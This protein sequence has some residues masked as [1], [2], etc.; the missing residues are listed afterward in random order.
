MRATMDLG[1]TLSVASTASASARPPTCR[2]SRA[3]TLIALQ[4]DIK[5]AFDPKGLLNP[6][7]IFHLVRRRGEV[8]TA[9]ER[10]RPAG[11]AEADAPQHLLD[12]A[13]LRPHLADDVLRVLRQERGVDGPSGNSPLMNSLFFFERRSASAYVM[14]VNLRRGR[15]RGATCRPARAAGRSSARSSSRTSRGAS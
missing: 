11:V 8:R 1:G 4:R 13:R 9:V 12:P 14:S 2:S 7:K 5:R 15:P 10:D 6:G 3:K